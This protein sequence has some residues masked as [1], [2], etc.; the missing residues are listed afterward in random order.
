MCSTKNQIV[1]S[2]LSTIWIRLSDCP[3][4]TTPSTESA[5]DTSYETSCAHVRIEPSSEDFDEEGHPPTIAPYRPTEP[6]ANRG[7][8]P[9]DP[10]AITPSTCQCPISQPEP[11]GIPAKAAR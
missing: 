4:S 8:S 1:P 11:N 5:S 6:R 9:I 7:I 2:C 3:I 10:L